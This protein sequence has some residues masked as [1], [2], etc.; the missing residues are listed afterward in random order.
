MLTATNR[1]DLA[2]LLASLLLLSTLVVGSASCGD[3]DL[4]FPGEVPPTSTET[5]TTTPTADDDD[6]DDEDE[7]DDDEN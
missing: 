5:P 7:D 3:D 2:S 6:D 4:I 1:N